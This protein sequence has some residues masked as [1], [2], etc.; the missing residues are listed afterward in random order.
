MKKILLII[1]VCSYF[2]FPQADTTLI[3][4]EIMF[5]P[6]SGNNEFI[7][8]F[9]LSD[10]ES[11]D[12]NGYKFKYYTATLDTFTDAGFGTVLPPRSYAIV[13][14]GDYDIATGIYA[15][16]IPSNALILKISDNIFGSQ[17]MANTEIRFSWLLTPANDTLDVYTY[18][19]NNA[20]AIS[21]EKIILNKDS[22]QTN[23]AN[24]LVINGTPGFKNSVSLTEFDLQM[25][26]L[27]FLPTVLIQDDD[28]TIT[29][30]VK[31][32][33][34]NVATNYSIEIYND[35]NF[36]SIATSNELIY[37]PSFTNLNPGDSME[38]QTF[39][40][41]LT[42]GEYQIIADVIFNEDENPNN[43]KLIKQF[44]VYPPAN[45]YNDIVIN[46]IMY[47]P[48]TGEPEWVELY[49]R[50]TQTVSI[51]YW[52]ISDA[53]STT[54]LI[55]QNI[56]EDIIIPANSF[57]VI[58]KDET[59]SNFY[60]VPST[61][62]VANLP[63]L[64]NTGDAVVIKDLN[65]IVI[66]S[67]YYLPTWGGSVGG[68]SLERISVDDLSNNPT[69]WGTSLNISKAT[70]GK[71][72]S[73]TPKENDLTISKF[74]PA[75]PYS[76]VGNDIELKV[77][78]KNIGLTNS[79]NFN[80]NFYGD[81]NTD[82]IPEP[83]ELLVSLPQN[84]ILSGDSLEVIY[85]TNQFDEGINNFIAY[86][87]DTIDDDTSN[88]IA[89]TKVTGV[90]INEIRGDIVINEF[91]F[92][93]I[94][95]EPE[96]IEIFNR[97]DK[98]I[99]LKNYRIADNNDT[100]VVITQSVWLNPGE[101]YVI[102][103][104]SSVRNFYNIPSGITFKTLLAL[105][106]TGD[107]IILIDSLNRII[108]S[109]EYFPTWGGSNGNSLE[110]ID[111]ELSSID[112]T[113]WKTSTS[114]F[115]ATPGYI[116]SVTKKD[117]DLAVT[118]ILFNPKF[119]LKGDDVEISAFVKNLGKNSATFDIQLFEDTNLDSIP[120]Q[121]F[122]QLNQL[123]LNADD[124]IEISFS[125]FINN[126]QDIKAFF[127]KVLFDSDQDTTN[128]YYY[129]TVEPGFPAQSIVINEIMFTPLGGE[130][131]WIE[132]YNRSEEAINLLGWSVRDVLTTPA[133]ALINSDLIIQPGSYIVLTRDSSILNFHRFIPSSIF[134]ISLPVLNNDIDGV[135]LKDQRGLTIDSVLYNSQWGGINGYSLERI[136]VDAQSTLP[137]NWASSIDIE[138]STPGRINSITPKQFDVR[139]SG[140][141][142]DPR[143]PVSGDD[144]F[145]IADIKNSGTFNAD[146]FIVEFYIDS[147]SN[148][149]IDLLLSSVSSTNLDAGDSIQ[150]I[151]LSPIL[152]IQSKTI[153]A[154]RVIFESDEDTLNNYFE[155]TV[156]PG[157]AQNIVIINEV[158]YNPADGEP[159][160]IEFVN[161]SDMTI[162][163]ANFSVSDVL[164][165]P[166]KSFIT[167]I[168]FF[169]EP[170]EYFIIARDSTI[171]NLHPDIEAKVFYSNFGT[172]GNTSDG[173]IIYDYRDGIIDSL[174]YHS[175][176]GGKKGYS[177]ERISINGT[178]ND[179]SN[180]STS[181]NINGSTPGKENSFSGIPSYQRNTLIINEIMFDPETGNSEYI[182]F[183]NLNN[184]SVNIGG[185][186]I[187]DENSN[188]YRLSDISFTIPSQSYFIL[189]SDST[190]L[191]RFNLFDYSYLTMVGTSS[192]GLV[193]TGE[194]ILLKD[195]KGNVIDSVLYSDNWHNR[196]ITITKGKSLERINPLLNGNDPMNW[197]TS[198]DYSGGTPGKVNSIFAE[199]LNKEKN[200]SVSPNPFS[201]DND[202]FEDFTIIN[203]NLT[204]ATAQVRVKIFDNKG[205]LL[206]TLL[207]NAPS[208]QSGSIIFDGLD[209]DGQVLRIGIYI[210]FL[211]A[212]NDNAGVV[213]TMRTVVVVARKL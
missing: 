87:E 16:L 108:D 105:N 75:L 114:I 1:F 169:I 209:D 194:L 199:N 137:V 98:I 142:F 34:S 184:D 60:S 200:I 189:A 28:V 29:A 211:E 128:N 176:W 73:I 129:K 173:V 25:V 69:N 14:E 91:M 118:N 58:S 179:S 82:S 8:I 212:M 45:N 147:D 13:F 99:D 127:I 31:N 197:N 121:L 123:N 124:S 30:Q 162:N 106:N 43:N 42:Q 203:Y 55:P 51:K 44:T 26:S 66:D 59:I 204:Q 68:K 95:P 46:E 65:G 72:N 49:N 76:I 187:E 37:S 24:S 110:R 96:W 109:L 161:A 67:V 112:S 133:T 36:D 193:N 165:T 138:Q 102:A 117:F 206:R 201:P 2:I 180:W 86:I 125:Y 103:S 101:Y 130:P 23:W 170:N 89:F 88:N 70:P 64:N 3:L 50:T 32:R 188:F 174:L 151:S 168:D 85:S 195:V 22:S 4:S 71:I 92:A 213:E 163:L 93:P 6:S 79:A 141:R 57:I 7:E 104:D 53:S 144:V 52:K 21:D 175:S 186:R 190:I 136:S 39:L 17:G 159:E 126:L 111:V 208:G 41:S 100:V 156:Q 5:I 210:V 171:Y 33:G 181:L 20:A 145:I 207:N 97:S 167:T 143:F 178:T 84:G 77:M 119:P 183:L 158:M 164:T 113:N 15:G 116:N 90:Q 132:L 120:D 185:W 149:I 135:I 196:N 19:P 192:L 27:N 83:S 40:Y 172:L 160:W 107:K 12:L 191:T 205:R 139:I 146:N 152:N 177:L 47:A 115:K 150:I 18:S 74:S 80:L 166:T 155:S 78:I 63:Y 140:L 157:E 54:T 9:N 35:L 48:L 11:V 148:N 81:V 153:A 38:V 94:S 198:V 62:F 154:V 182:E 202:G 56:L 134:K 10:T 131:E 122:S 61:I